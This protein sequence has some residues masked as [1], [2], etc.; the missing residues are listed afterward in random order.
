MIQ[1]N[2]E[3]YCHNCHAFSPRCA[4]IYANNICVDTLV[5]CERKEVCSNLKRYIEQ[6]IDRKEDR[7]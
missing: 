7:T 3:N 6:Q 1:L 5:Q 4:R 2:V